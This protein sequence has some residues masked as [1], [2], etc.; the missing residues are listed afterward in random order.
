METRSRSRDEVM[1]PI[2]LGPIRG[3]D[4]VGRRGVVPERVHQLAPGTP[5]EPA[6]R[7]G[8]LGLGLLL[9]VQAVAPELRRAG[10]QGVLVVQPAAELLFADRE[11]LG[12]LRRL[13][14]VAERG[15]EPLERLEP[16]PRRRL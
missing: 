7:R 10:H 16:L 4:R 1:G 15:A 6:G 2:Q 12:V 3:Q 13:D 14:L 11:G 8:Q 9:Q 5:V